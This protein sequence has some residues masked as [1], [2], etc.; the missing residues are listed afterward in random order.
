M[1]T[2]GWEVQGLEPDPEAAAVARDA[3]KLPVLAGTLEEA[4]LPDASFDAVTLS[5]VIEHVPEPA[6]ILAACARLLKRGGKLVVLTPCSKSLGHAVFRR[7]WF[8]LDPPRHLHIFSTQAIDALA[9]AARL[10]I[11][12]LRTVSRPSYQS[13]LWSSLIRRTERPGWSE[14]KKFSRLLQLEA[15]NF[16]AWEEAA[17][18]IWPSA[19]EELLLVAEKP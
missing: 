19:G 1:R 10:K 11:T 12:S 3:Y 7:S 13:Y 9:R 17:R 8:H 6:T 4:R 16:W 2:L 5:H 18:L 14:N 15:R